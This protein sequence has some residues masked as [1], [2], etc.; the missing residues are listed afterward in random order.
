MK[1]TNK[2]ADYGVLLGQIMERIRSVQYAALRAVNK[3][4]VALYWDIGRTLTERQ[5]EGV[6]GDAVVK[7]LSRD[8]QVEFPDVAGFS[9]RNLFNMSEF[10]AAYRAAPKLQ[11]LVAMIG[12]AH[13]LVIFQRCKDPLEREF[14]I[15]MTMKFGWTRNVLIHQIENQS[16]EKTLLGQTNFDKAVPPEIRAQAKL[17]MKDE[18]TFDF[19]ELGE[20]HNERDLERA[21]VGRIERFLREKGGTVRLR[22]QPVP[23]GGRRQG[24][25]HRP[26]ALP[27]PPPVPGGDRAEGRRVCPRVRGEGAVLPDCA[28]PPGSGEGRESLHRHHLVQGEEPHGGGIRAPGSPPTHRRRRLPDRQAPAQRAQRRVAGAS[29]DR[30][31][32]RGWHRDA[33]RPGGGRWRFGQS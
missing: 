20:E 25:L 4:L 15:R 33:C 6:R 21:L 1:G 18:Y 22:R 28:R 32:P 24:V 9:W 2:V 29:R 7:Q 16:Y 11:P 5:A 8:L 12:W 23:A 30:E 3:E 14:Y 10:Y 17:A 19:L 26:P 13:N 27:P 31:V